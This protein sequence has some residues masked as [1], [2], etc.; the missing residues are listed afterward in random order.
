MLLVQLVM[1]AADIPVTKL[2]HHM[3]SIHVSFFGM[4]RLPGHLLQHD[5]K[6]H[7]PKDV[8]EGSSACGRA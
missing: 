7:S 8:T 6:S 3:S 1:A 4:G 2:Q 5:G